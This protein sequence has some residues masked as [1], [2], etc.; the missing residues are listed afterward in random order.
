MSL[1]MNERQRSSVENKKKNLKG[2]HELAGAK[3]QKH[4]GQKYM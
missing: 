1:G 2:T 4:V 3:R